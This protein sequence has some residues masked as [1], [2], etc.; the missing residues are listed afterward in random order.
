MRER[1]GG[2]N[3]Q[4]TG[5]SWDEMPP[6]LIPR[7]AGISVETG[8]ISVEQVRIAFSAIPS[9]GQLALLTILYRK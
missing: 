5:W 9:H 2:E 6:T 7:I 8:C 1:S 4:R 3:E